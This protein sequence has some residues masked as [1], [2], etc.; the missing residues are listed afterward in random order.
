MC[1]GSASC[2]ARGAA[3]NGFDKASACASAAGRAADWAGCRRIRLRSEEELS[4]PWLVRPVSDFVSNS[5][6]GS[7][8]RPPLF[9]LFSL[10]RI[11]TQAATIG[12][13]GRI[14]GQL[15]SPTE[16]LELWHFTSPQFSKADRAYRVC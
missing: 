7:G 5:G 6:M 9:S 10:F 3:A 2:A 11:E 8:R 13:Q 14:E 12:R 15:F 16:G 1:L 4:K